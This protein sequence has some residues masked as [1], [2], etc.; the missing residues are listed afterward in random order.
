[1]LLISPENS[2]NVIIEDSAWLAAKRPD[3]KTNVDHIQ[4]RCCNG[5]QSEF[6]AGGCSCEGSC[7]ASFRP[8]DN[9]LAWLL[10]PGGA[11]LSALFIAP[12][13]VLALL[14][15][16]MPDWSIENFRRIATNPIYTSILG[17]TLEIS[18]IVTVLAFFLGYPIAYMLATGG[19]SIRL[20]LTVASFCRTLQ[21]CWREPLP[22]RFFSVVAAW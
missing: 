21:A 8:E 19:R 13:V 2:A 9:G 5:E 18:A 14:S 1:M 4:E 22:G 15:F 11:F 10:L 16:G 20:F 17:N 6:Y 12:L 3:G 7:K